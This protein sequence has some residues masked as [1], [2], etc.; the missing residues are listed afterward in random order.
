LE[1]NRQVIERLSKANLENG[2]EYAWLIKTPYWHLMLDKQLLRKEERPT[3]H[4]SFLPQE[5]VWHEWIGGLQ[6]NHRY[7]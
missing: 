6:K 3:W 2:E 7:K 5:V 4:M 1:A